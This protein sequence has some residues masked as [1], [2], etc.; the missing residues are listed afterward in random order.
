MYPI[1]RRKKIKRFLD[2]EIGVLILVELLV[3]VLRGNIGA[4]LTRQ[5]SLAGKV[6]SETSVIPPFSV[7]GDA[8]VN[9]G[10]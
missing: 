7:I 3:L 1:F 6:K 9:P 5:V 2:E 4:S 10:V 8:S